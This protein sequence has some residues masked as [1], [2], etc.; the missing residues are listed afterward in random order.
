MTNKHVHHFFNQFPGPFESYPSSDGV[1]ETVEVRCSTTNAFIIAAQFWE[2]RTTSELIAQSIK[3]ALNMLAS[4]E[5]QSWAA[6]QLPEHLQWFQARFSGPYATGFT[7]FE[8]LPSF[9]IKCLSTQSNFIHVDQ[10]GSDRE[11]R[12]IVETIAAALNGLRQPRLLDRPRRMLA[13][14]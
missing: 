3:F 8:P 14:I 9:D 10:S 12:M 11:D 13:A 6:H 5:T 1:D 2:E 4:A 7:D